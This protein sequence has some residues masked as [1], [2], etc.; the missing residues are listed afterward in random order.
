MDYI[1]WGRMDTLNILVDF[2]VTALVALYGAM[3][4]RFIFLFVF[5]HVD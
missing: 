1:K 4:V 2:L 5:P 3:S